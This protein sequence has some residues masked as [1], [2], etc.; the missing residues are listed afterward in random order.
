VLVGG[1]LNIDLP[2]L[3]ITE[4]IEIYNK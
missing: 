1:K 4:L 2:D 3:K